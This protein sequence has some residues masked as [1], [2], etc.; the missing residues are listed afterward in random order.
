MRSRAVLIAVLFASTNLA[1]ST[2]AVRTTAELIIN[3]PNQPPERLA[4]ENVGTYSLSGLSGLCIITGIFYG[5]ACWYYLALP[6]SDETGAERRQVN[7]LVTRMGSCA[8]TSDVR[9]EQTAWGS[10]PGTWPKIT[11]ANG[12]QL[13]MAELDGACNPKPPEPDPTPAPHP[14]DPPPLVASASVKGIGNDAVLAV[15]EVED[16]SQKFDKTTTLQLTDYLSARVAQVHHY[17]VIPRDQIRAR[18]AEEK[19]ESYRACVDQACQIEL[20]KALAAEKSLAT[21]LLRIGETCALTATLFDLRS[22]TTERAASVRTKCGEED[23]VGALEAL[24]DDLGKA[25]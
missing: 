13:S 11:A 21:K 5:G 23:L 7:S 22:E 19:A 24:V 18:L 16:P 25:R 6:D 8:I 17:R 1:C 12:R 15:F 2:I 3:R 10:V 9:T 20:G 14:T 4:Y